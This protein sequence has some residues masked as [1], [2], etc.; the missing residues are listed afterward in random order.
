M[1][2]AVDIIEILRYK[3][4]IFGVPIDGSTNLFCD[5]GAVCVNTMRPESTLCLPS[6]VRR[7]CDRNGQSVKGEYIDQLV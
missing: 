3:V 6:Q 7:F 4:C 2:N 5:N 1:K